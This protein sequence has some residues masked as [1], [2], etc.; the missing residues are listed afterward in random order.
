MKE[1]SIDEKD[2]KSF[3]FMII[4][5]IKEINKKPVFAIRLR[6]ILRQ[7]SNDVSQLPPDMFVDLGRMTTEIT[8]IGGINL[9]FLHDL[10]KNWLDGLVAASKTA[11]E[12]QVE[13]VM[14][15]MKSLTKVLLGLPNLQE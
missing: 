13:I 5:H 12:G 6:N 15:T 2:L 4:N 1:E 8:E 11:T 3:Y 9:A 10:Q 7:N 14:E